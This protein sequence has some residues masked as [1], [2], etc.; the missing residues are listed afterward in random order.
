MED[1][2]GQQGQGYGYFFVFRF[3][4]LPIPFSPFV[5]FP[6][7][8]FSSLLVIANFLPLFHRHRRTRSAMVSLLA[9]SHSHR[10]KSHSRHASTAATPSSSQQNIESPPSA[11]P[12]P[13]VKGSARGT[14]KPELQ[15]EA[16]SS[17][18]GSLANS[19][20]L[21]AGPGGGGRGR[22]VEETVR[23]FRLYEALRCGDTAAIT[24][25]I[26]ESYGESGTRASIASSTE[27]LSST[28]KSSVLHLAV[29]CAELPVL[30]YILSTTTTDLN[31]ESSLPYLDINQRDPNT[32][33]T[34][35]H[36]A[37]HLGRTEVV[38]LLLKQP[39]IND[40]VHNYNNRTPLEVSRTPQIFQI[41]QL[42]RSIY[43]E[44]KTEE[45]YSLVNSQSYRE[46]ES[47]LEIPRV[48]GLLDLNTLEPPTNGG[49]TLLHDA[50]RKKDIKLIE[51]L[52]LHGADPFRRDKKGKLPQD[53]IKD[54][55]TKNVLKKSEAAKAAA[56]GIEE[57][58]VLGSAAE[59]V[60]GAP[61]MG[62]DGLSSSI[63]GKEGRETKGYLKKWTNYT[64]GYKLRWFVLEDGVLS[65]YKHQGNFT[66]T[67]FHWV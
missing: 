38:S 66:N 45:L 62:A 18:T 3:I 23:N 52:L 12:A 32:G 27:A 37:A 46:I 7:T 57:R 17:S 22:T 26:R 47:L 13:S 44:E 25:A 36:V 60:S 11:T 28:A 19:G 48:K 63:G 34:P 64:T 15:P 30:E 1:E 14:V 24:R 56:R 20:V 55:K 39:E 29:Q 59:A 33:N 43:L 53:V 41:L 67:N 9:P 40:S 10:S 16:S 58:A 31:A 8:P 54:E 61:T 42:A 49:S 35:L 6:F 50:A 51:I 65:Y 4:L 5:L 2:N 21:V